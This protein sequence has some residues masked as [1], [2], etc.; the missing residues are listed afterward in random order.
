MFSSPCLITMILSSLISLSNMVVLL[1]S[2]KFISLC[3][4]LNFQGCI[5]KWVGHH[6]KIV[7][8]VVC[9]TMKTGKDSA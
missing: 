9:T 4:A 8:K 6:V 3:G 2:I 1:L 7:R 5:F